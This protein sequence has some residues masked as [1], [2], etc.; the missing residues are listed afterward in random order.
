MGKKSALTPAFP[1]RSVPRRSGIS[2]GSPIWN[3]EE[4]EADY[5]RDL[6][7]ESCGT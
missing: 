4:I 2:C 7:K 1:V 5:E 3:N 6:A